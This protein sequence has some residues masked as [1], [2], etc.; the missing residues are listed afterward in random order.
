MVETPIDV[1]HQSVSGA[2]PQTARHF[3]LPLRT[4]RCKNLPIDRVHATTVLDDCR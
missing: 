3:S 2:R 4:T 1:M